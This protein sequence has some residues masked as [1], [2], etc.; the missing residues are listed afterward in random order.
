[1]LSVDATRAHTMD[2]PEL[3]LQRSP[4]TAIAGEGSKKEGVVYRLV[5]RELTD[6]DDVG[7]RAELGPR[8]VCKAARIGL[9]KLL[10]V[11]VRNAS[12]SPFSKF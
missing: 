9:S 11:S 10:L 6:Y 4:C 7:Y 2:T 5:L 12:T 1:M 3:F 8:G